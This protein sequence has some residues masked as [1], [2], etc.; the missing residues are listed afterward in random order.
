MRCASITV[1]ATMGPASSSPAAVAALHEAG[2]DML[3]L[4][5]AHLRPG[6]LATMLEVAERGG[7]PPDRVVLDLQGAKTRLSWLPSPVPLRAGERLHLVPEGAI[8]AS[9]GVVTV[10]RPAFLRALAPGDRLRLDDGR[11]GLKVLAVHGTRVSVEAEQDGDLTSRM[12][13][14]RRGQEV[15]L[16]VHLLPSDRALLERAVKRGVQC[17]AVSY[18]RH[19]DLLRL[20]RR[21]A[22]NAAPDQPVRVYAKLEQPSAIEA[23]SVL[24]E[25]CDALWLCRGDLGAEVG[26]EHLPAL[27]RRLLAQALPGAP[28]LV[29]GQVLHHMCASPR[30][31]RSEACHVADLVEAGVAGFVLSDET[32]IGAHGPEAVR[33]VKRLFSVGD[34]TAAP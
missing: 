17:L 19:P 4:N 21:Y 26:I 23:W 24:A 20:V 14:A 32:A 16:E 5:G 15:D 9:E 7:F 33:W 2:A 3:R 8:T 29:A 10:D 22:R 18:A 27:Q 1:I 12:G 13:L 6:Q 11:F 30:P 31:T 34:P 25:A 28:L